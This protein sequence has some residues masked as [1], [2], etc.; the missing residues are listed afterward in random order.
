MTKDI[1]LLYEFLTNPEEL[2]KNFKTDLEFIDWLKLGTK[3][4]LIYT[5]KAFEESEMYKYCTLIKERIEWL[6]L[7]IN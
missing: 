1:N 7:M 6:N 5:L 4:D 2:I 3:E